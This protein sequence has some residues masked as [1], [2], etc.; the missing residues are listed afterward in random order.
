MGAC[1]SSS[2]LEPARKRVR[3]ANCGEHRGRSGRG[4]WAEQG[5]REGRG[6]RAAGR[7]GSVRAGVGKARRG[8]I[9]T[10]AATG[11]GGREEDI[12]RQGGTNEGTASTWTERRSTCVAVVPQ[13]QGVRAVRVGTVQP[14]APSGVSQQAVVAANTAATLAGGAADRGGMLARETVRGRSDSIPSAVTPSGSA[15]ALAP[16]LSVGVCSP[17]RRR[18]RRPPT[19]CRAAAEACLCR[20]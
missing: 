11:Y 18:S 2:N 15:S 20:P 5:G 14:R 12:L 13:V 6:G 19:Q 7:G 9:A 1:S 4:E 17:H 3:S 16:L 10:G 8:S